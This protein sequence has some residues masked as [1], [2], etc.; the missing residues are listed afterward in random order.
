[1]QCPEVVEEWLPQGWPQ[2]VLPLEAVMEV[3]EISQEKV[4]IGMAGYAISF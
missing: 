1:M 2:A 4:S 3:R